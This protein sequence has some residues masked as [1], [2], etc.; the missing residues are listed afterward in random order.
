M[1]GAKV[2]LAPSTAHFRSQYH[3]SHVLSGG[4][5][6]IAFLASHSPRSKSNGKEV[7]LFNS[8]EYLLEVRRIIAEWQKQKR[9]SLLL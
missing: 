7:S 6:A 5:I 2:S 8:S 9:S 1:E 3:H 4:T